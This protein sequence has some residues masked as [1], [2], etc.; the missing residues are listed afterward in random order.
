MDNSFAR[1]SIT[2]FLEKLG[3][4]APTPGGG[5]AAALSSAQGASLLMMVA[6]HTIG[7]A[8]YSEFEDLNTIV[9]DEAEVLRDRFI[10]GIDND[11]EAFLKVS[12][13]FGMP[14]SFSDIQI[15]RVSAAIEEL[16]AAGA[17]ISDIDEEEGMTAELMDQIEE[18]LIKVRS[19]AIGRASVEAAEAPLSIMEDS[20]TAL[21]L[22]GSMKGRS[23]PNLES[24]ILVAALCL[25]AGLISA[26]FNVDANLPAI[27]KRDPQLAQSMESRAESM[28]AEAARLTREI[29]GRD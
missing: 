19:D 17:E 12:K 2:G 1:D 25:Q 24:D 27:R 14:K 8:R 15:D 6:N 11:A 4:G 13:A 10:K 7:K 28:R 20:L 22:A 5:A 16:R 21:R 9:R 23:N 3:S 18:G 29:T 26:G